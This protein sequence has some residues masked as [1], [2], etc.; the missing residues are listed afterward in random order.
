MLRFGVYLP[1]YTYADTPPPSAAVLQD[2]ARRAEALGFDS[3]WVFDHLLEA[4]PSYRAAFL[5]PA[6][7]LMLAA[8]VTQRVTIGTGILV[9]PLRDPVLTA[10][11]FANIDVLSGGRL[12]FGVGV[13]WAQD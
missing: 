4:P 9:L 10:K 1:T 7:S 12:I 2:Y 3:I 6:T 8:L 11:T 13:G 5:E